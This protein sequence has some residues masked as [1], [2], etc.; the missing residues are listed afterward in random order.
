MS[1]ILY[2]GANCIFPLLC[3]GEFQSPL[4]SI[5]MS[6]VPF[7]LLKLCNLSWTSIFLLNTNRIYAKCLKYPI[8]THLTQPIQ[9]LNPN[10]IYKKKKKKPWNYS[11]QS[12]I[13]IQKISRSLSSLTSLSRQLLPPLLTR[14]SSHGLTSSLLMASC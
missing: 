2:F 9:S 14:C 10:L 13:L 7:Y 6:N 3:I 8:L 12:L 11:H 1:F 5:E 4:L